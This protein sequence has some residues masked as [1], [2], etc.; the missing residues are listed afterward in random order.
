MQYF[1][2]IP[3]FRGKKASVKWARKTS[4]CHKKKVCFSVLVNFSGNTDVISFVVIQSVRTNVG[5]LS[6]HY[7]QILVFQ[8]GKNDAR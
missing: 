2:K 4:S 6:D 7:V 3:R 5:Q 8:G 1:H